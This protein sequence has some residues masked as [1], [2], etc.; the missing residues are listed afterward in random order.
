MH[1]WWLLGDDAGNRSGVIKN[2]FYFIYV[3]FVGSVFFFQRNKGE[4]LA[5]NAGIM[6][7]FTDVSFILIIILNVS[8]VNLKKE[9]KI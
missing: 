7:K 9:F 6:E 2:S 5:F 3:S 8:D 1:P 4:L